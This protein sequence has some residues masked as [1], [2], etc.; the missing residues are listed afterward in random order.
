[1]YSPR[2]KDYNFGYILST[3]GSLLFGST[4]HSINGEITRIVYTAANFTTGGSIW[5]Q[6][7]SNGVVENIGSVAANLNANSVIYPGKG[8]QGGVGPGIVP[9]NGVVYYSGIGVGGPFSGQLY[10]NYR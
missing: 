10:F 8:V 9:V 3:A 5:L 7:V 2:V 1:M 4:A 6:Q